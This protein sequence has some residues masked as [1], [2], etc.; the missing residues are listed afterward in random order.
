MPPPHYRRILGMQL[1]AKVKDNESGPDF[2][3]FYDNFENS[4]Q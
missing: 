3:R 1:L 2:H 4:R